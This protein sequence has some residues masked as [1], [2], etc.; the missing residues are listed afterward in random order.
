MLL[1]ASPS[2][3]FNAIAVDANARCSSRVLICLLQAAQRGGTNLS[4][5]R[6]CSARSIAVAAVQRRRRRCQRALLC[7]CVNVV[8][9]EHAAKQGYSSRFA[10]APVL[11]I[12]VAAVVLAAAAV[13]ANA[14]CSVRALMLLLQ[15]MQQSRGTAL[16]SPSS[17]RTPAVAFAP[18]HQLCRRCR[19][20]IVTSPPLMHSRDTPARVSFDLTLCCCRY[21]FEVQTYSPFG[22]VFLSSLPFLQCR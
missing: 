8:A 9:A 18:A 20:P 22:L 5:C 13:D 4:R 3:P 19:H 10:V 11:G 16:I 14:R 2:S 7:A 1:E 12:V 15:N 6:C 21:L 17:G